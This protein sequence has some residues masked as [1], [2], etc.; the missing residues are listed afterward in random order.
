MNGEIAVISIHLFPNG[1]YVECED[2]GTGGFIPAGDGNVL[3]DFINDVQSVCDPD[4]RFEITDKGREM[5]DK[6][7]NE[8][9]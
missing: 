7:N 4:A 8:T 1:M 3:C 5:L 6:L 9:I 2:T